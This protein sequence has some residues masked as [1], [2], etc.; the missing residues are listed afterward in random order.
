M[1]SQ[2][3]KA[4]SRHALSLTAALA[5]FLGLCAS[6][7]AQ[8]TSAGKKVFQSQ[9]SICH[10]A[11]SGRN[12]TGPSLFGV[13]GRH[14]GTIPDFRYSS[15][16]QQSGLSWDVLTLDRYLTAPQIVVPGTLM[17]FPGLKDGTKRKDLIAYLATLQ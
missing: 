13:V 6:A 3:R 12:I 10:S 2:P 8:D 15:A 9:C 11:Q 14:S 7:G 17:T 4:I 1:R 16:N 5:W